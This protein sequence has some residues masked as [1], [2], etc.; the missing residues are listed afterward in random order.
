MTTIATELRAII[1]DELAELRAQSEECE[2]SP[3]LRERLAA[4]EEVV[5]AL[6]PPFAEPLTL[7][8]FERD[9]GEWGHA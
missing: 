4:L 7:D 1:E 2:L 8:D 3:E 5:R 6:P 9:G